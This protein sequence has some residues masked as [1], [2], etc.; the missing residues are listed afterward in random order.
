MK[1]SRRNRIALG[2]STSVQEVNNLLRQHSK[3]SKMF[4]PMGSGGGSKMQQRVMRQWAAGRNSGDD[5][6]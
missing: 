2:S 3:M 4:K 6:V 5:S 1:P